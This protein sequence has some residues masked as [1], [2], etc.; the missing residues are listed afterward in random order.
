MSHLFTSA[1]LRHNSHMPT[2]PTL[3]ITIQ[4]NLLTLVPNL[5]LKTKSEPSNSFEGVGPSKNGPSLLVE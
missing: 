3:T 1:Y 4:T 5:N 2:A